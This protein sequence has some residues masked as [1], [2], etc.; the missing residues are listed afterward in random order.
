MQH[1][2]CDWT[3]KKEAEL[4][5]AETGS[6]REREKEARWRTN[7]MIQIPRGFKLPQ[8]NIIKDRIIGITC[9]TR[10]AAYIITNWL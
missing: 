9:L 1:E 2:I 5:V 10:W 3:G 8:V 7:R 6:D 4:R